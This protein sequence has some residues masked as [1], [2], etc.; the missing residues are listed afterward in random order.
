MK[1]YLALAL[2]L[3]CLA[4]ALMK[5]QDVDSV[6]TN[7]STQPRYYT[8]TSVPDPKVFGQEYYVS[9]P[10]RFLRP[11][12]IDAI[13]SICHNLYQ[14]VE[15]EL[16]VVLVG[17]FDE[18]KWWAADFCQQLFNSW[19]IG[20]SERNTGVLLFFSYGTR[21]IRIHTGYGMEG[22]LPD[23]V[24]DMII[25]DNIYALSDGDYNKG[26]L[27]MVQGIADQLL[28]KEAKEELLLG[29]TPKRYNSDDDLIY[30]YIYLSFILLIVMTSIA[31]SRINKA[32]KASFEKRPA[33]IEK[34][35]N[36]SKGIGCLSVFFPLTLPFLFFAFRKQ[37]K[38]LRDVPYD[39]PGCGKKMQKL[40]KED[41]D[42]V[43]SEADKI[44]NR[45][46]IFQF[47]YWQC[48][49][50]G[51]THAARFKDKAYSRYSDCKQ[52][53]EHAV[54]YRDCTVKVQ[55]TYSERGEGSKR[56]QCEVC[57]NVSY[58]PYSIPSLFEREQER[59][60]EQQR[61]EAERRSSYSGGSSRSS[62]SGSW[63]GGRSG[64]GGA[65]RKF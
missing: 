29:W 40:P 21:D 13:N 8:P 65:G 49:S 23:A 9:D 57:G 19:G 18:E 2:T 12:T 26:I 39:C 33:I 22:L 15:V 32:G 28:T 60:R 7:Q 30:H 31:L 45:L 35:D 11:A 47:D 34:T 14:S 58:V 59:I 20:G 43:S 46:H 5:G 1:K 62:S 42:R 61:K 54:A 64:G 16:A 48:P 56:Y 17:N 3:C 55:P 52:C 25:A 41:F 24:C 53:G 37:R 6:A 44:E 51:E 36:L 10:D 4:P 27:G 38:T 63:G 50:C